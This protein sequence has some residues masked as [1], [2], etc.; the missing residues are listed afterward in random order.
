LLED[1]FKGIIFSISQ[2]DITYLILSFEILHPSLKIENCREYLKPE[3][4][5]SRFMKNTNLINSVFSVS[6]AST[7]SIFFTLETKEWG[8]FSCTEGGKKGNDLES[9]LM[10]IVQIDLA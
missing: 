4:G 7:L 6:G 8:K 9:L 3:A 5:L 10:A 2:K 1:S